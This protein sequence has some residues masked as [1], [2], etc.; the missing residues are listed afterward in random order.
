MLSIKRGVNH[1]SSRNVR[2]G[3]AS[4]DT[5]SVSKKIKNDITISISS[6][7]AT[8]PK[9]SHGPF[10]SSIEQLP[11]IGDF[12][13]PTSSRS[14]VIEE[15]EKKG[16]ERRQEYERLDRV[17][18]NAFIMSL[19]R[20][21]M[22]IALD[23]DVPEEGYA[24]IISL[25][26]SLNSKPPL[27]TQRATLSILRSL[28]P[29][30]LPAFFSLFFSRP[31]PS[32]SWRLNAIATALSCQWLMGPCKV[33]DVE[34]DGGVMGKGNGVKVER[35]RYLEE[36]GCASVCINS[37]KIPTQN[38]FSRDMNLPLEMTPNY[39]DFSCQ[40]SF[41]KTPKAQIDDLAFKTPC[42]STCQSRKPNTECS[43][44]TCS[45][46]QIFDS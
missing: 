38:F 40:F 8:G 22:I 36:A 44:S 3:A 43:N 2:H 39:E 7:R 33:N 12:A 19:F 46:I 9:L 18:L 28:F 27:E 11:G 13:S 26:R 14:S 45:K 34:V 5:S 6:D 15:D 23:R 24:G 35:C 42:Y 37:C 31:F 21:K 29:P 30:F 17:P 4:I 1:H 25:T 32:F 41:G 16:L 20:R 10:I